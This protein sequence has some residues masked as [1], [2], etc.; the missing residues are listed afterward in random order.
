V[1][2]IPACNEAEHVAEVVTRTR[3][4]LPVL[5]VDDGS[6]DDTAARAEAAGATVVRQVPNQ[7]KGAALQAGFRWA[8]EQGCAAV[9][10][11]DADGQHDPA[12][13]PLF[14]DAYR[15]RQPD[16]IIGERSFAQMPFPRNLTNTLGADVF[17]CW[18]DQSDNWLPSVSRRL[19][20]AAR[21]P[22]RGLS[23]R[24]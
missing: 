3:A 15:A 16:L 5:V 6:R 2:L 11:L 8:L 13:I 7:G 21:R 18:A 9:V 4:Y 1:A 22:E 10:M 24:R 12:E 14:L 23:S 20:E 17:G 19:M